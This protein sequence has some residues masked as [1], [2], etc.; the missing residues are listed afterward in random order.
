MPDNPTGP[1]R[2]YAPGYRP[3]PRAGSRNPPQVQN[4]PYP[5]PNTNN[6]AKRARRRARL[7]AAAQQQDQQP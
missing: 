1:I 2:H 5:N 3:P 7:L 4:P 6:P